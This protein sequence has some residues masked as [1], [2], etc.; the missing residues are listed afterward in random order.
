[1]AARAAHRE[2]LRRVLMRTRCSS[3]RSSSMATLTLPTSSS[4][5]DAASTTFSPSAATLPETLSERRGR[6]SNAIRRSAPSVAA[7]NCT[8][9]PRGR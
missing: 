7:R 9:S 6:C 2:E 3:G 8:G 1:M 5:F 4:C